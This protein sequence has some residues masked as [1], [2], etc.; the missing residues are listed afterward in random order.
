M[1][2][3]GLVLVLCGLVALYVHQAEAAGVFGLIA[4][5]LAF[6]GTAVTVGFFW[7]NV[8]L[9]PSLATEAP[10]FLDAEEVSGPA[11]LG[12]FLGSIL[13][14]G[15]LALFGLSALRAGVYPRL[16]SILFIVGAAIAFVPLPAVTI[17]LDVAVI[18]FGLALLSGSR[19]GV[20]TARVV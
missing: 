13:C 15:G 12:F 5:L 4:F 20:G 17:V 16:A 6:V 19:R 1:Y 8:F 7:D 3:L 2:L 9:V 18:W 11:D 10:R 14:F